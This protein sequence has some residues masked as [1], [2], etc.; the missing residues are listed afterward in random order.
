MSDDLNQLG[1]IGIDENGEPSVREPIFINISNFKN[2][3]FLDIRK[4]Y[5]EG[6]DWKPTKKGITVNSEQ[7]SQ[8]LSFLNEKEKE[9]KEKLK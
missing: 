5:Q 3:K 8:L 1:T 2:V 9:I 7:F 6:E 4:Y